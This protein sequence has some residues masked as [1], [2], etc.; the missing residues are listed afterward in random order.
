M[1]DTHSVLYDL[2]LNA[3]DLYYQNNHYKNVS[4]DNFTCETYIGMDFAADEAKSKFTNAY[5]KD[6]FNSKNPLDADINGCYNYALCKNK[7]VAKKFD[8]KASSKNSS[9]Q[10]I[11]DTKSFYNIQLLQTMNLSLGMFLAIVGIIYINIK[12]GEE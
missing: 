11:N 10:N 7:K 6:L 1:D 2:K 3:T 12:K 5:C 8:V 4:L 9:G